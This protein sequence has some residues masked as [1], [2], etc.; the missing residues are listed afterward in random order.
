MGIL[1]WVIFGL[2]A[3]WLAK[4][5]MPGKDPGGCVITSLLGIGGALLGGWLGTKFFNIGDVTGFNLKSFGIAV[6]GSIVLLL[7]Y[8]MFKGRS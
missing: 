5:I 7:L 3:G 1:A 8:R 6:V 2:I 4:M